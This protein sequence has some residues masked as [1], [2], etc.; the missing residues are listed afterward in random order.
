[1]TRLQ[2]AQGVA[3][4]ALQDRAVLHAQFLQLVAALGDGMVGLVQH[5]FQLAARGVAAAR[6]YTQALRKSA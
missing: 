6:R 5:P 1:M 4:H 2:R 3:D